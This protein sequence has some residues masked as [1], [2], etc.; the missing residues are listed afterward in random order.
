LSLFEDAKE[1]FQ[2]SMSVLRVKLLDALR[3]QFTY[4][5]EAALIRLNDGIRPYTR[6]VFAENER[7]ET[8][9]TSLREFR[10]T[11]SALHARSRAVLK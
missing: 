5:S 6:F 8:T 11:L 4:E 1:K 7:I 3:T 9:Q 10:Q 2:E